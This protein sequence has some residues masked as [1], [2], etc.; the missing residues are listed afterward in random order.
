MD[1]RTCGYE[2]LCFPP[3]LLIEQD[4]EKWLAIN[5]NGRKQVFDVKY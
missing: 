3:V 1:Q 4:K 5:V 2:Y